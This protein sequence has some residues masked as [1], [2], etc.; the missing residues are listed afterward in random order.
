ML[1]RHRDHRTVRKTPL[2]RALHLDDEA[3]YFLLHTF[4]VSFRSRCDARGLSLLQAFH[5]FDLDGNG[6]LDADEMWTACHA[7][8]MQAAADGVAAAASASSSGCVRPGDVMDV[9]RYADADGNGQLDF[10][11]F[12]VAFRTREE[13]AA[14][15]QIIDQRDDDTSPSPRTP[16]TA[17][18]ADVAPADAS[19]AMPKLTLMR[20]PPPERPSPPPAFVRPVATPAIAAPVSA[21][22]AAPWPSAVFPG[23]PAAARPA[24][25]V[26][27]VAAPSPAPLP[28]SPPV[29]VATTEWNCAACTY[30][31]QPG[32]TRCEICD[33]PKQ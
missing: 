32:R 28:R 7:L 30:T 23:A 12:A 10:S 20:M 25:P 2:E 15:Y 11:E 26:P 33:T 5:C 29:I 9:I 31:N 18:S 17:A 27:A 3:H 14:E 4:I 21:P 24:A 22:A 19:A 1:C 6:L 8:G 16:I 13:V